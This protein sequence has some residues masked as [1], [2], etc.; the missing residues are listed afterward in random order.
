MA[1]RMIPSEKEIRVCD[2][3]GKEIHPRICQ[4]CKKDICNDHT[5]R[6]SYFIDSFGRESEWSAVCLEC[7][8]QPKIWINGI[9]SKIEKIH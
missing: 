7:V 8:N 1:K 5:S 3:C 6:V 9:T 2:Y 4:Y